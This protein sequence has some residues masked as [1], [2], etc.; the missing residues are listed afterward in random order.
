MLRALVGLRRCVSH[1]A[2]LQARCYAREAP[3]S[4][5]QDILVP[6]EGLVVLDGYDAKGFTAGMVRIEGA[7]MC[8]GGLLTEW[9]RVSR[10]Q[11][12]TIDSLALMFAVKPAPD[13]LVLG[14]GKYMQRVP[15]ALREAL[16]EQGIA[17]EPASTSNAVA[18][19]NILAQEGRS[20]L[21]ALLPASSE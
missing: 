17:I 18:T 12:V 11:D 7:A 8:T 20:V 5:V 3:V 21:G 13:L 4:A 10:L 16:D 19:Y 9:R 15:Q 14:C 6:D 2:A 1:Q